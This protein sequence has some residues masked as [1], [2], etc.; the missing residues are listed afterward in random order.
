MADAC[1][2]AVNLKCAR[3][4]RRRT[5]W[6]EPKYPDTA[7]S[8]AGRFCCGRDLLA[9]LLL[10][11]L[12][13][14]LSVD[15]CSWSCRY[16]AAQ[17][18]P[19]VFVP[20]SQMKCTV[21]ARKHCQLRNG[22]SSA[23]TP[24][25]SRVSLFVAM[26]TIPPRAGRSLQ[27]AVDSLFTQKRRPDR[28]IVS[29]SSYY[30]RF[31]NQHVNLSALAPRD[32]LERFNACE[33]AGPGT[34]LLCA[35]PRLRELATASG[36]RDAFAVLLDDD[37]RYRSWALQWLAR[38][39]DDDPTSARHA[40]SYDVYTITAEG[41][42]VTGGLH[43]G[44]LV[45]AGHALFAMRISELAGL[46]DFFACVRALEPRATYHDDVI[47]SMFLQDVRGHTIWR[48]GGTPYETAA[49]AFPDVHETTVSYLSAGALIRLAHDAA[50]SI[51]G[52]QKEGGEAGGT[53]AK[54]HS[55][56]RG[57]ATAVG[58]AKLGPT[59]RAAAAG[60]SNSS[61]GVDA[62]VGILEGGAALLRNGS[63][64]DEARSLYSRQAV[65]RAMG[66][67]R[68]KILAEGLC[69]VR[70]KAPSCI[71]AWCEH[72]GPWGTLGGKAIVD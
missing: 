16:R 36:G 29:A 17:R 25:S 32:G 10:V 22:T 39:I 28:V 42:A 72:K 27:R 3:R 5:N 11:T 44:L 12:P 9:P 8:M 4:K 37:L 64:V 50:A 6:E 1:L 69:G 61:S 24:A 45:G 71:G 26:T 21:P 49:K 30:K 48:L 51:D 68:A 46:D 63:T 34:K 19:T 65:T 41:R 23:Q 66:V 20:L 54:R 62:L 55:H 47:L 56:K 70:R 7:G 31:P 57:A 52:S 60:R 33:D 53:S 43:P 38:A 2:P 15:S 59:I 18:V 58:D 40:Y 67:V 14:A 13:V 35:L